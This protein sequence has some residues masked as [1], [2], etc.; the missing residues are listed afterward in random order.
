MWLFCEDGFLSI[1]AVRDDARKLLV[2]ARCKDDLANFIRRSGLV[3]SDR[4]IVETPDA[5]YRWRAY[6]K[7]EDVGIALVNALSAV[8]YDNFKHHV[9][10]DDPGRAALYS[11]VWLQMLQLQQKGSSPTGRSRAP[12]SA[13]SGKSAR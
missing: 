8:D 10:Q 7:R 1:V 11:G 3:S 13:R 5:D 2:R 9:G 6:M 12:T 4:H